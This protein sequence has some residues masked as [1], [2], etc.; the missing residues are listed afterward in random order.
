MSV[1]A[2]IPIGET[3]DIPFSF[4]GLLPENYYLILVT[5]MDGE[6]TKPL[7]YTQSG[8]N[9]KYS[10]KYLYYLLADT[11]INGIQNDAP[12]AEVYDIRG[13][14]LGKASELKSLPKGVYIINKKKV[15]NK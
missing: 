10:P 5:A 2:N 14:R 3:V 4:E 11:G 7:N 6:N 15:I 12:D 8:T 13:V 1:S 9:I